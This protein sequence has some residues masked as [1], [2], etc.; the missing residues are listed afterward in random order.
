M[1]ATKKREEFA[2]SD[3]WD[4]WH[5]SIKGKAV[6]KR[7]GSAASVRSNDRQVGI[8]SDSHTFGFSGHELAKSYSFILDFHSVQSFV[9]WSL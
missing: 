1:P 2:L 5:P 8:F 4:E 9:T 3:E 7:K 6:G